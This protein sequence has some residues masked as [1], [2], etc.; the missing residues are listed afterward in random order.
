MR[1][2]NARPCCDTK[3]KTDRKNINLLPFPF[4]TSYLLRF[5]RRS[6]GGR[7]Y[8]GIFIYRIPSDISVDR[9]T[10]NCE[11]SSSHQHSPRTRVPSQYSSRE[12]SSIHRVPYIIFSSILESLFESYSSI[13]L[14]IWCQGVEGRRGWTYSFY[15]TLWSCIQR[16]NFSESRPRF[17]HSFTHFCE[18]GFHLGFP[19]H[20]LELSIT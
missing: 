11:S 13:L 8:L 10:K 15:D 6:W 12:E 19:T 17:P 3:K 4:Y 16:S 7:S 1:H 2:D 9:S 14:F 5:D 20:I 18:H